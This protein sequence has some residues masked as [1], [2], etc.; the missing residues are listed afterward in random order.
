MSRIL[1]REEFE[2]RLEDIGLCSRVQ[3]S[4]LFD[5]IKGVNQQFIDAATFN[6]AILDG[7]V[8][9]FPKSKPKFNIQADPSFVKSRPE[10]FL[11]PLSKS[12]VFPH[13][14]TEM[15]NNLQRNRSVDRG[16][17]LPQLEHLQFSSNVR[18]QSALFDDKL[19]NKSR[20]LSLYKEYNSR[21]LTKHF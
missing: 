4:E 8:P 16:A 11:P 21:K 18:S 13:N 1:G 2:D 3:A 12:A 19:A 14:L 6:K 17:N 20:L 15:K 10:V 7:L 5:R 9:I